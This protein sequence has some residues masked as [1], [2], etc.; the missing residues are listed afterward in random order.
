[1]ANDQN[2]DQNSA[3]ILAK[4][5]D[6]IDSADFD[7]NCERVQCEQNSANNHFPEVGTDILVFFNFSV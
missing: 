2:F 5:N 4:L 7:R 3:P 6:C 1:M